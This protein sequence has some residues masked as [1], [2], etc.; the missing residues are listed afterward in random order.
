MQIDWVWSFRRDTMRPAVCYR[1]G[2]NMNLTLIDVTCRE[3]GLPAVGSDGD[4]ICSHCRISPQDRRRGELRR[5]I[6]EPVPFPWL[7]FVLLMLL[8]AVLIVALR[9]VK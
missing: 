7:T 5:I 4:M 8:A 9:L 3:C 2:G 6:D 1:G